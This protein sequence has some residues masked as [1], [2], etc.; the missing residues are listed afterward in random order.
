MI[1]N[2][3]ERLHLFHENE[4]AICY[5]TLC[6]RDILKPCRHRIH[7]HC[8][9][10]T[11]SNRCPICRQIVRK[12]RREYYHYLPDNSPMTHTQFVAVFVSICMFYIFIVLMHAW[13]KFVDQFQYE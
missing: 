12:P 1:E 5:E 13:L 7:K 11:N 8:F 6:D 3:E 4:C 10:Q 2:D 9:L